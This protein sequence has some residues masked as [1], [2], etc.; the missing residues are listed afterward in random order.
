MTNKYKVEQITDMTW[1]YTFMDKNEK[2]ETLTIELTK[3][4][5]DSSP[6]SL[7]VL[8]NKEGY[9][10]KVLETYWSIDTYVKD[11]E[12]NCF[13]LYNPQHKLREDGKATIINFEY[14][15]EATEENKYILINK[16]YEL[17]SSAKGESATEEKIRNIKEYAIKNNISIYKTIPEG[18]SKIS[19]CLTA[20]CGTV[21]ISNMELFKSGKRKKGILLLD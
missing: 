8:W 9:I 20:P 11:S 18:W 17:F 16:V 7:P 4:K 21:W 6:K 1:V 15:F 14:M 10:D 5:S 19:G 3:C 2:A 13:G 12:G